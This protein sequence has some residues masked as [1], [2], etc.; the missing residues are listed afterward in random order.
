MQ[1][2]ESKI[3]LIFRQTDKQAGN[4]GKINANLYAIGF[5]YGMPLTLLFMICMSVLSDTVDGSE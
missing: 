5:S 1:E 3:E 2:Q 4:N